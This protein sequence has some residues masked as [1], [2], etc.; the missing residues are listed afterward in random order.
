MSQSLHDKK[1]IFIQ[2]KEKIEDQIV[3]GQLKEHDQIPSTTKMVQFYKV[4]HIT[5]LKGMNLLVDE[6]IIYKKRG[7]GMFV[8][9]GA[10]EQ[11]L[12]KRKDVFADEY[13]LPMIQEAEK[14]GLTEKDI[15]DVIEKMKGEFK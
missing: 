9:E 6:G 7:V 2:M 4:N 12:E 11:L 8:A 10:K 3:K 14:L 15:V 13:V 5:V 1:P